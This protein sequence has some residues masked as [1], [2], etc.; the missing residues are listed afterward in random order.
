MTI[1]FRTVTSMRFSMTRSGFTLVELL[2]VIAIIAILLALL[3]PAVMRLRLLAEEQEDREQLRTIG[4][5]WLAYARAHQ[6]RTVK[7]KSSDPFD[8]WIKKIENYGEIQECLVSPSDPF[9]KDRLEYMKLFPTRYSSSFVLNPYF[10]T[11]ILGPDGKQLH[12]ERL[13]DCVSLSK[14]IAI[15]PVSEQAGVPG[16]GYIFPQG[17]LAPPTAMAWTRTTG[18]LGIQPDRFPNSAETIPGRS[19]YFF[20]DG[21]VESITADRIKQWIDAGQQF[22]IPQQ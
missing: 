20:A 11:T 10:A 3:L 4:H 8:A 6:G 13:S 15:M 21:H 9:R 7:H 22:L 14:A 18:R 12:C 16:P 1:A 2:V 19:N 5:A 17:W